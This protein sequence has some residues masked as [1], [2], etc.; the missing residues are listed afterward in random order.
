MNITIC[1]YL[2]FKYEIRIIICYAKFENVLFHFNFFVNFLLS[3]SCISNKV[4]SF[5]SFLSIFCMRVIVSCTMINKHFLEITENTQGTYL[6][7]KVLGVKIHLELQLRLNV[8]AL[9]N[10]YALS[11]FFAFLCTYL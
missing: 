7:S 1:H 9:V 11:I 2:Y 10:G 4:F 3:V 8:K 5:L 6:K